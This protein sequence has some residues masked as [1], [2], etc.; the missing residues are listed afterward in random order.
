MVDSVTF[1]KTALKKG[2]SVLFLFG[3]VL[4]TKQAV[5]SKWQRFDRLEMKKKNSEINTEINVL[6]S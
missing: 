6:L 1:V 3:F 2:S 5:I 4:F